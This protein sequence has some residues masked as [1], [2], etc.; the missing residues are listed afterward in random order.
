[1]G[2]TAFAV[3]SWTGFT[4]IASYSNVTKL[5]NGDTRFMVNTTSNGSSKSNM[6]VDTTAQYYEIKAG[7]SIT[8]EQIADMV[9]GNSCEYTDMTALYP[10]VHIGGTWPKGIPINGAHYLAAK[11]S[12]QINKQYYVVV[13]TVQ[14]TS[15]NSITVTLSNINGDTTQTLPL[16]P[17]LTIY[18]NGKPTT[19]AT[20][21]HGD[22]LQLILTSQA[23][24]WQV[25]KLSLDWQNPNVV[26]QNSSVYG[27]LKMHHAAFAY[28]EE[29]K[30]FT[31]LITSAG[32]KTQITNPNRLVQEYPLR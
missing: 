17:A 12:S 15:T 26:M 23:T 1:M 9:T 25:S 10:G 18:D 11:A 19:I 4:G 7:A 30:D 8:P 24:F 31:P 22:A 28:N 21:K 2:G 13:G 20:L 32:S 3:L 29:G 14:Q 27:I 5:A 6:C 16:S